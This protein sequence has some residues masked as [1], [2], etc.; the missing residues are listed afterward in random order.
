MPFSEKYEWDCSTVGRSDNEKHPFFIHKKLSSSDKV[1]LVM[2]NDA[3]Y[4][5]ARMNQY[6][7]DN[8]DWDC[9]Q[10]TK[11]FLPHDEVLK[12]ISK[13][14]VFVST[15]PDESWGITAMEALGCGVPLILMAGKT[16]EHCSECI[17]A[18]KSHF[19]K[20]SRRSVTEK[21]FNDAVES[22]SAYSLEKRKEI[23]E[24]TN[25]KHTKE[26]WVKQFTTMIDKRM[27]DAPKKSTLT[28]FMK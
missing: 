5:S 16:G 14:K 21:E 20:L 7:A 15:W 6:V 24:E 3:V 19:I 2:T 11:R 23:Y 26:K 10:C 17:P 18:D 4:K 25:K 13:S 8:Q 27:K 12:N 9:P 22:L 1:S 28:E